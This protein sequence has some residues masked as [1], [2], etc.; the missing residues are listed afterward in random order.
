M[1]LGA[2]GAA[3]V[4]LGVV[5]RETRLSMSDLAAGSMDGPHAAGSKIGTTNTTKRNAGASVDRC[6]GDNVPWVS[7]EG[8]RVRGALGALARLACLACL[9]GSR[10]GPLRFAGEVRV[11][12]WRVG[13]S[14]LGPCGTELRL[15]IYSGTLRGFPSPPATGFGE[16]SSPTPTRFGYSRRR[17]PLA[18]R[19]PPKLKPPLPRPRY[20]V[21]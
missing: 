20:Y 3:K 19:R 5:S 2:P 11:S 4:W 9:A 12:S 1:G 13:R 8:K 10:W 7:G 21:Q 14:R 16:Q 6:M 17:R 18:S 15:K